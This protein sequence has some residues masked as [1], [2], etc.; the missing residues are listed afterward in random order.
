VCR[1]M[2][3]WPRHTAS[4]LSVLYVCVCEAREGGRER[5]LARERA[6]ACARALGTHFCACFDGEI[7]KKMV[8]L[9]DLGSKL[10]ASRLSFGESCLSV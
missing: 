5:N 10:L 7:G 2:F 8:S 4:F 3:K 9:S 1:C 6:R